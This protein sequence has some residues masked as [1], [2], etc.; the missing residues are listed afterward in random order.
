VDASVQANATTQGLAVLEGFLGP[1]LRGDVP[2]YVG[3]LTA[4][5]NQG[6]LGPPPT[7]G[8]A[9]GYEN[10]SIPEGAAVAALVVAGDAATLTV[11][12]LSQHKYLLLEQEKT[13][14]GVTSIGIILGDALGGGNSGLCH[15][16]VPSFQAAPTT[17]DF[18]GANGTSVVNLNRFGSTN[19]NV[20]LRTYAAANL[21][22]APPCTLTFEDLAELNATGGLTFALAGTEWVAAWSGVSLQRESS[23]YGWTY[24]DVPFTAE[25]YV[26]AKNLAEY[27]VRNVELTESGCF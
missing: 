23:P 9:P 3:T 6:V 13:S 26:N 7:D 18:S 5:D 21:T 17:I 20:T 24:C 2:V 8:G 11:H 27:G 16:C 14:P 12:S 22:L 19:D 1:Y 15:A 25:L 10:Q 4:H